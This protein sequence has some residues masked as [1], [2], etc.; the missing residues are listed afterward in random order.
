MDHQVILKAEHAENR[1][2]YTLSW[3]DKTTALKW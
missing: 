1:N 2:K 3:D